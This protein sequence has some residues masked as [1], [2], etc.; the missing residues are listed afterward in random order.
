MPD[1]VEVQDISCPA[2]TATSSP[3]ET[4]LTGVVDCQVVKVTIRIPAG[5]AGLTGIALGYGH[6]AVLPR[7]RGR[8]ISGD[9]E[10]IEYDMSNYITGPQWAA[11]T[12]NADTISHAWE[13]R[14][15]VD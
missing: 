9:D 5:H 2:G 15:E 4:A 14:F 13:V 3:L 10:I 8:F 6:N 11:F 7:T 1:R 12:V